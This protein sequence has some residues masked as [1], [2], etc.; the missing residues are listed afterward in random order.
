M[1]HELGHVLGFRHEH[2]HEENPEVCNE[3]SPYF[4]SVTDYDR[5]SIMH[6]AQ[7]GGLNRSGRLS[8]Y[9]KEGAAKAYP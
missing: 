6:Y 5:L 4:E 3:S 8:D 9:D 2:I 1:L 7:C